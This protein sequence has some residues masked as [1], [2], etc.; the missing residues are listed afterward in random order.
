MKKDKKLIEWAKKLRSQNNRH[1]LGYE[2]TLSFS[3]GYINALIDVKKLTKIQS[4][5]LKKCF[6]S[7]E[8]EYCFDFQLGREVKTVLD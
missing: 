3:L 1:A 2:E 8:G 6:T 7:Y 5:I 4:K